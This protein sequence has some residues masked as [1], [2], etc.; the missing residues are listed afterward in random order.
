MRR[1]KLKRKNFQKILEE[2][3]YYQNEQTWKLQLKSRRIAKCS[4]IKCD[5]DLKYWFLC[6]CVSGALSVPYQ[7]EKAVLR[8]FCFCPLR[9]YI[10]ARPPWTNI[11]LS[12]HMT[13]DELVSKAE[14]NRVRQQL[15]IEVNF[16]F[17]MFLFH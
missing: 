16:Y 2:R 1:Q 8:K 7:A 15:E 5:K 10:H 11:K 17:R 3:P 9:T 12:A 14:F 13:R 4:S 6:L